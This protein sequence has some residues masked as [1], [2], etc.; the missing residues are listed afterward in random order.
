MQLT[1]AR[2]ENYNMH[3]T[4]DASA[5][6]Q[7][8]RGSIPLEIGVMEVCRDSLHQLTNMKCTDPVMAVT[9]E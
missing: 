2:N 5:P 4:K 3:C 9:S 7:I 1:R 8:E 6:T